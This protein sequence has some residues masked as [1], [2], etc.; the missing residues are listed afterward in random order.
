M[1]K[2]FVYGTLRPG[3]KNEV[4]KYLERSARHMGS[5]Q[6]AGRLYLVTHY[7]ALGAPQHETEW[8]KGDLFEGINQELWQVLDKYEGEQYTREQTDVRMDN[9]EILAAYVFRY[10]LPTES[11]EWI[12]SGDWNRPDRTQD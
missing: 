1:D 2:L 10:L 9:G 6:V 11:L 8:I 5:G 3:S 4:A 7:P 12:R